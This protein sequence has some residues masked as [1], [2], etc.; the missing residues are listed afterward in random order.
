MQS[1]CLTHK[2]TS[3]VGTLEPNTLR[4]IE[5]K[6]LSANTFRAF[7]RRRTSRAGCLRLH[8]NKPS[9][10]L[11]TKRKVGAFV[12]TA[13]AFGQALLLIRFSARKGHLSASPKLYG[14]LP[15]ASRLSSIKSYWSPSLTTGSRTSS[16]R[17]QWSQ[18]PRAKAATL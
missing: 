3:P 6:K 14:T 15:S 5:K 12:R 4:G 18:Y 11:G 2:G 8:S 7:I 1:I 13:V 17:L 9:K 10:R 16:L